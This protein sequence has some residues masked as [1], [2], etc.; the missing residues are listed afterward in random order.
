MPKSVTQKL[1][2][3][4]DEIKVLRSEIEDLKKDREKFRNHFVERMKWYIKLLGEQKTP[5]MSYLVEIESKFLA[6]VQRWFW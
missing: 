6:T 3:A 4:K 2:E 5:N 1:R